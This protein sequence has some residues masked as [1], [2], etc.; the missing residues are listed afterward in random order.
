[1]KW[2]IMILCYTPRLESSIIVI[3]RPFSRKWWA[4]THIRQSLAN[5]AEEKGSILEARVG[6]EHQN[7]THKINWS[8]ATVAQRDSNNEKRNCKGQTQVLC[9]NYWVVWYP[10]GNGNSW[11]K[12]C[13]WLWLLFRHFAPT[14][15]SYQ[16]YY[17]GMAPSIISYWYALFIW[18]AWKAWSFLKE[19]A[20]GEGMGK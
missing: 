14:G 3:R 12:D 2:L 19:K 18:Y 1:M 5:P 10:C 17:E 4:E 8:A 15:F 16:T 9:L 6:Q 11:C 7:R 20:G 13:P